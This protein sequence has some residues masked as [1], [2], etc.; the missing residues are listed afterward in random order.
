MRAPIP[1][2]ATAALAVLLAAFGPAAAQV[3]TDLGA[4]AGAAS[5]ASA[6]A[7]VSALNVPSALPA[8]SLGPAL[9]PS[10]LSAP[11]ASL[12]PAARPD[13]AGLPASA[14]AAVP[15]AAAAPEA[16][17]EAPKAA[18]AAAAA[19]PPAGPSEPGAAAAAPPGAPPSYFVQALQDL[20]VSAELTTRLTAFLA[21]RHPGDQ[22]AIYHGLGHS[23]EVADFTARVVQRADLPAARKVL[24]IFSASLHDVDPQR[25]PGTPARVAATIKYLDED[26]AA[27]ALVAEF[28]SRYGFTPAQVGALIMGT[29]FS[30]DPAE[31]KARQQAF[32][33]AAAAAF[34]G[35]DFGLV[36]GRRLA[37]VDQSS[38]YLGDAEGAKKRVEGLAHEIRAQLESMGKGPGPTD[39]M[40]LAGTGKFLAVLRQNPDFAV[41]PADLQKRFEAVDSYFAA[42]QTPESWSAAAA[43]VPARAPPDVAAARDYVRGIAAGIKLDDRQTDALLAQFF[44]EHGIAPSSERAGAVR[45]EIVPSRIAAEDESL[46][47]LSPS[48]RSHRGVLLKLAADRKTTPAAI[49]A[50]LRR[51]GVLEALSRLGDAAFELQAEKALHRD[52]LEGAVA[53]YPS[54]AQGRFMREI[55]G[56]MATAS[57]K[58]IEEVTRD[59]VFAYVDFAGPAVRRAAAGRDPDV[60]AYQVVFYVTRRDGRWRIDGYRQNRDTGRGD[61]ELERN[62]KTWLVNGGVP[63]RD[64]E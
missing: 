46:A 19:A 13:A 10:L 47:G 32:A 4:S 54:G 62:L 25:V 21:A 20:G 41:L 16:R 6:A 14:L 50:V 27:S 15:A 17:R 33:F 30:P 42:K 45:R 48:L 11:A 59:G 36:W 23:R 26:P 3:K 39:A 8:A 2:A 7:G 31:M 49:E 52:E 12:A 24:L 55:A 44:E 58:S 56:H 61:A 63:A 1:L 22:D 18:A 38:T 35:E 40:I 29:D 53:S 60:K 43:P 28:G 34:P 51:R 37:F 64:L 5:G 57:G 9:T